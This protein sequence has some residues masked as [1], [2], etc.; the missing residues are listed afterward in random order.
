MQGGMAVESAL[1]LLGGM[2]GGMPM[3]RGVG[4]QRAMPVGAIQRQVGG[5]QLP[6]QMPVQMSRMPMQAPMQ[7]TMGVQRNQGPSRAPDGPPRRLGPPYQV[8]QYEYCSPHDGNGIV[9]SLGLDR[10][11]GQWNNPVVCGK[12]PPSLHWWLM[13]HN[14]DTT[15]V[16]VHGIES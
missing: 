16:V 6:M 9:Y 12:L 13:N 11:S 15:T 1:P 3:Q 8:R 2:Q 5:M 10:R 14:H 4:M 7:G